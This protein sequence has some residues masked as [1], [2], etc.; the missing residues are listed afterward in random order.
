[1][2]MLTKLRWRLVLTLVLSVASVTQAHDETAVEREVTKLI[3]EISSKPDSGI[4]QQ[5]LSEAKGIMFLPHIVENQLGLGRKKGQGIFLLRDEKGE[6]GKPVP[7]EISGLSMGAE[8]G[9]KVTDLVVIY[10][11][12]KAADHDILQDFSLS[13]SF[14]FYG[15]LH[16][17]N[18]FSGPTPEESIKK[19]VLTYS[20]KN[21]ILVGARISREHKTTVPIEAKALPK[22][23]EGEVKMKI[24]R[25]RQ[26]ALDP[27]S[28]ETARL[29]S[30]LTAMTK[31][32]EIGEPG[33]KDPKVS[34]TGAASVS[35][36]SR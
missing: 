32:H 29:I 35:A 18:K 5:F 36:G 19:D 25:G 23:D 9:H 33:T 6:W 2:A 22:A 27:N 16:A 30:L 4:P 8:A 15:G 20:R 34:P 24:V 31:T 12:R 14:G 21:G 1:M 3:E 13:V 26:S 10:R 11:T 17:R 7:I 28:P